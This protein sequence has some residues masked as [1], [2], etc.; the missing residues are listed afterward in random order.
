[1]TYIPS[2]DAEARIYLSMAAGSAGSEDAWAAHIAEHGAP[3]TVAALQAGALTSAAAAFPVTADDVAWQQEAAEKA[4]A[5]LLTPEHPA[6]PHRLADLGDEAPL[7]LWAR[8]DTALLDPARPAALI[9]GTRAST[10]FGNHMATEISAELAEQGTTVITTAAY[11]IAAAAARAALAARGA[12]V[13][14]MG[15]GLDLP[16]PTGNRDLIDRIAASGL[17]ITARP[18]MTSPTPAAFR[19]RSGLAAALADAVVIVEAGERSGA[20]RLAAIARR[21]RRPVG[22]VCGAATSPSSRGTITLM[23]EQAA[24]PIG[25][26]SHAAALL[27]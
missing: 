15:S 12:T 19:R 26:A 24:T 7:L 3:A 1:M 18:F 16:Y 20:M 11:G 21:L 9:D 2:T 17:L 6:W 22:A 25:Q 27:A 23:R 8:G 4:G 13:A 14:V 5:T 10:G